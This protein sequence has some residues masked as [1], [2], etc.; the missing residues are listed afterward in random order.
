MKLAGFDCVCLT[1]RGVTVSDRD[2]CELARPNSHELVLGVGTLFCGAPEGSLLHTGLSATLQALAARGAE[3]EDIAD[4]L[5]RTLWRI[6][7]DRTFSALFCARVSHPRHELEYVNAGNESALLIRGAGSPAEYL[8]PNGPVLGLSRKSRYQAR[9]VRFEPG[10]TLAAFSEGAGDHACRIVNAVN[11][12][13]ARNLAALIMV[14][15][16]NTKEW[17]M[18]RTAV[19]IHFERTLRMAVAA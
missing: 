13:N 9:C 15:G 2:F 6:A 5:N 14:E 16:A 8:G 17:E 12:E 11:A 1:T 4:D 18:D 3:I 7:P 19:T 10:D